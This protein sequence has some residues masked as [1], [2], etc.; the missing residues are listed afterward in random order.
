MVEK[1]L[2]GEMRSL[3]YLCR[4][5]QEWKGQDKGESVHREVNMKTHARDD[6]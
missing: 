3:V 4:Q 5:K 6:S 2:E 1:P